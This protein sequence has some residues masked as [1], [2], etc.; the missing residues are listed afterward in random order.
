MGNNMNLTF[1]D[2]VEGDGCQV[3]LVVLLLVELG[4]GVQLVHLEH[5]PSESSRQ[6]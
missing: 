1:L 5:P 4:V 2:L 3:D 6:V